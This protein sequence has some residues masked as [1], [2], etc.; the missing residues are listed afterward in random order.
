MKRV[1]EDADAEAKRSKWDEGVA[2]A[3]PSSLLPLGQGIPQQPPSIGL[4]LL[5]QQAAT[6]AAGE[7][8]EIRMQYPKNSV[9]RIIG[10]G[11]ATIRTLRD[12][13]GARVSI[14]KEVVPGTNNRECIIIGT[15]AQV[16]AALAA[17]AQLM[18]ADQGQGQTVAQG[19]SETA[20]SYTREQARYIIGPK[21]VTI[22]QLRESSQCT[23]KV[24]D[25]CVPG[26]T[27]QVI[28]YT[29]TEAQV[30]AA[31]AMVH[32]LITNMGLGAGGMAAAAAAP[33]VDAT[34]ADGQKTVVQNVPAVRRQ[35]DAP[36]SQGHLC[37]LPSA[38]PTRAWR[39]PERHPP[40]HHLPT[41]HTPPHPPPAAWQDCAGKLIG[42]SGAT[43]K[44]LRETTGAH[45]RLASK[46]E[47]VD[48]MRAVKLVGTEAQAATRRSI[49]RTQ[50]RIVSSPRWR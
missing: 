45:I 28:T 4:G 17:V 26:T 24:C 19:G 21:G 49:T 39:P 9:G 43:I 25:D 44:R 46:D 29:G 33:L 12:T 11:G 42:K 14:G 13:T 8:K 47:E 3:L 31:I 34:G 6:M 23:I 18:E 7:P 38:F 16:A 32:G 15:D 1:F 50:H 35:S 22:R 36:S 30:Q 2:P 10:A 27:D 40:T 5:G 20:H 41:L 48:G 37:V